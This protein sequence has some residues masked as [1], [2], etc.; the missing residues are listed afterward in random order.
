[1]TRGLLASLLATTG[2]VALHGSVLAQV[3]LTDAS[4]TYTQNFDT[5]ATTGNTVAWANDSTLAGWSLF[6]ASGNAITAYRAGDGGV[7]N[8]SFYSFGSSGSSDRA[9]GGVA[10]GGAYFG[11]PASGTLA[12]WIVVGFTNDTGLALTSAT[13]AFAG[14]QWRNGGNASAQTMALQWGLGASLA[15][16]SFAPTGFDWASPI[17]STTAAAVDGNGVGRV[18]SLGGVLATT[19]WAPGQTLWLRWAENNDSGNDHGLAIDDFSL[20]VT[21]VPEPASTA[22]LLAGLGA[23]GLLARRR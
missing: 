5:L 14:E 12:G 23:L 8:G 17:T 4:A 18:P 1:M 9:L 3:S 15:S 16:T 19:G 21:A 10:S 11:S 20:A 22:L 7:N 2:L 6:N 13:V